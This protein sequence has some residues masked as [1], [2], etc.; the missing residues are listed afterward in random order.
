MIQHLPKEFHVGES[1][2]FAAGPGV[3][4][5]SSGQRQRINELG[6]RF[7]SIDANMTPQRQVE[8]INE[9]C[10][11]GVD[12]LTSFTLDAALAEQAY[13]RAASAGIPIVTFGAPSASATSV[14]RQ[15]V[16]S[17]ACAEDAAGYIAKHVPQA[18]ILVIGGPPIPALAA[19]THHFLDAASRCGLHVVAR[20]DNVEDVE[21][22]ARPIVGA[23]LDR[24]SDIDAIWCFNDYTALAA[25]AELLKRG[26]P[27]QSGTDEGV[28]VSGIGG[29]ALAIAAIRDR[30]ITFTY[31]SRP[32]ETGRAAIGVIETVLVGGAKPPAEVWIDF[33][34]C[35]YS[36]VASYIP[37]EKR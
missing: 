8:H 31:D 16:D 19:R 23:L 12:A 33:A 18:R 14:V 36:N 2:A 20:E 32:V 5:I 34:R 29:I 30:R 35:D 26:M 3:W 10:K 24:F 13:V 15:H 9:L 17:V 4:P 28:I 11:L 7:T 27:V 21:E 22:T 25:A 1:C 6:W 37:W